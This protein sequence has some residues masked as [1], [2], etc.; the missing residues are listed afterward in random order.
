LAAGL[1]V[2]ISALQ[3]AAG[4]QAMMNDG[5]NSLLQEVRVVSR[6]A[7]VNA[8]AYV[9]LF[10]TFWRERLWEVAPRD[11]PLGPVAGAVQRRAR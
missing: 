4:G 10:Q 8:R 6:F 2:A 5:Q 9:A 1:G 3:L 7:R 11:P